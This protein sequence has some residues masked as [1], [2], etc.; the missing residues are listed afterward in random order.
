MGD[1]MQDTNNKRIAKN[2]LFLYLRMFINMG[3]SLYTSRIILN[4]LGTSDYGIYGVVGSVVVIFT[5]VNASLSA[6]TSRFITFH[7]GKKTQNNLK[8]SL[9]QH[10]GFTLD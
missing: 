4:V 1:T 9:T 7:M 5:F 3:I 10:Y 6:A 2:T 8:L